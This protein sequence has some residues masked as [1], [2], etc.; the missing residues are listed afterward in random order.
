MPDKECDVVEIVYRDYSNTKEEEYKFCAI[1]EMYEHK[2][3][4]T[5]LKV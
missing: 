2:I 4:E 3:V 5:I 1:S